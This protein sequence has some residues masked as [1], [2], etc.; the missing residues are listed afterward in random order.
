MQQVIGN[1]ERTS[2]ACRT[3]RHLREGRQTME[4]CCSEKKKVLVRALAIFLS[5]SIGCWLWMA[6]PAEACGKKK[7]KQFWSE[8]YGHFPVDAFFSKCR[9][10][11]KW[12]VLAKAQP[13]ECYYGLGDS[14]IENPLKPL[15]PAISILTNA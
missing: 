6:M 3:H 2:F 9:T 10:K 15:T 8:K 1:S 11:F 12:D 4:A 7:L 14:A 13:D 5:M